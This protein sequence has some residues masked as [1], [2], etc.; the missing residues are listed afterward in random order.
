MQRLPVARDTTR[1]LQSSVFDRLL[2]TE[3]GLHPGIGQGPVRIDELAA[4]RMSVHRDLEGLLNAQRPWASVPPGLTALRLS[5]LQYGVPNF[6]SGALNRREER[7]SLREEIETTIRRFE[8][9]LSQVHVRLVDEQDRLRSTLRLR[10][11]ALLRVE[12]VVVPIAFDTTVNATTAEMVL[13]LQGAHGQAQQ[14][15]IAGTPPAGDR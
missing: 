12:P 13:H 14:P 1:R 4:L 8:P 6:T 2:D 11:E 3:T 7:E 9:R 5:G 10:I 15:A